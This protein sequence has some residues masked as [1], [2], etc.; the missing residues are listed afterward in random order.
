MSTKAANLT[1]MRQQGLIDANT[2]ALERNAMATQ[3]VATR[4]R[5]MRAM[6]FGVGAVGGAI[7][8]GYG[9][10]DAAKLQLAMVN[11][12]ASTGATVSQL[13][14]MKQ[15]VISTSGTTAQ[16]SITIANEM[17]AL[18]SIGINDPNKL[19]AIFPTLA[20]AADVLQFGPKHLDPVESMTQLGKLVHLMG[21]Y[22]GQRFLDMADSAV[23]LMYTQ[24]EGLNKLISQGRLFI[25]MA[26]AAG[27]SDADQTTLEMSM[28][29]TGLLTGRGGSGLMRFIQYLAGSPMITKFR[30]AK[31]RQGFEA[32]G[33]YDAA[34]RNK[35][36][37]PKT[38]SIEAI[39]A[40]LQLAAKYKTMKHGDWINALMSAMLAQGAIFGTAMSLPST[41]T[42]MA[43]NIKN[44]K[45]IAPPGKAIETLWQKYHDTLVF[46]FQ[47]F[48]TNIANVWMTIWDK[49]LPT[50]TPFFNNM[51]DALGR[52]Q[53]LLANRPDLAF[54][55]M[56]GVLTA[57]A[58]SAVIAV[59]NLWRLNDSILAMGAFAKTGAGVGAAEGGIGG[60]LIRG[61]LYTA[62]AAAI[63][64]AV[65]W[66]ANNPDAVGKGVHGVVKTFTL[67]PGGTKFKPGF[68]LRR[69]LLPPG[70]S[71]TDS[72]S[73]WIQRFMHQQDPSKH[74]FIGPRADYE[75]VGT[76]AL[77][78]VILDSW[79]HAKTAL[80]NFGAW[81][82]STWD[83]IY[84]Y[85]KSVIMQI[86]TLFANI[87]PGIANALRSIPLIGDKLGIP[88]N[89]PGTPVFQLS[90]GRYG[91]GTHPPMPG[92]AMQV[93]TINVQM[94]AGQTP[95]QQVMFLEKLHARVGIP[96]SSATQQGAGSYRP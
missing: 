23:R 25:P 94:P 50:L 64:A 9:I 85:I 6:A 36:I 44:F 19:M 27:I 3:R 89:G 11:V 90:G 43:Q 33:F 37:D 82:K 13:A 14:K 24:P 7:A 66:A 58:A 48:M 78:K 65:W 60:L 18:A 35:F 17:G 45:G 38:G 32:L 91:P 92:H 53:K 46:A 55:I 42:Q 1:L 21:A 52:F 41:I 61:G 68:D 74:M 4:W 73:N 26:R 62:I 31:Q 77:H 88:A 67:K 57:V 51:A 12:G 2:A 81:S 86:P 96:T 59:A 16:S 70:A 30:S 49:A 34:G 8:I 10:A 40:I 56:I 93:G 28:G 47:D 71:I 84:N 75:S 54:G 95:L 80:Q 87:G 69:G 15:M 72:V 79:G 76:M 5:E 63:V 39:P 83:S 20:K 22:S 29:Q